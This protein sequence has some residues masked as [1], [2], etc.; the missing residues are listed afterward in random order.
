MRKFNVGNQVKVLS[1]NHD[2]HFETHANYQLPFYGTIVGIIGRE[3][4]RVVAN[5]ATNSLPYC[6]AEDELELISPCWIRHIGRGAGMPSEIVEI[7]QRVRKIECDF[8]QMAGAISGLALRVDKLENRTDD[9]EI[10]PTT[11]DSVNSYTRGQEVEVANDR[12]H[13]SKAMYIYNDGETLMPHNVF[14]IK[15][16]KIDYFNEDQIRPITTKQETE[17]TFTLGQRVLVKVDQ[18][19]EEGMYLYNDGGESRPHFVWMVKDRCI[20]FFNADEVTQ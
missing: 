11:N 20:R 9:I 10:K 7:A 13:W 16:N 1:I 4:Y 19:E 2:K 14:L 3:D 18:D 17:P 5:C 8:E 12:V 15:T 6:L